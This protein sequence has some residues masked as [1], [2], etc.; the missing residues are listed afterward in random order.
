MNNAT[1]NKSNMKQKNVLQ[2][3]MVCVAI[4]L[5]FSFSFVFPKLWITV[6][7]QCVLA[8]VLVLLVLILS[9][10]KQQEIISNQN[11]ALKQ[12]TDKLDEL[13]LHVSNTQDAIVQKA[14]SLIAETNS[15]IHSTSDTLSALFIEEHKKRSEESKSNA[16][17]LAGSIERM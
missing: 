11:D 6:L 13:Q 12:V 10:K 14:E 1:N 15:K 8:G 7:V 5:A 16:T 9:K 2:V 17:A 3:L 4:M